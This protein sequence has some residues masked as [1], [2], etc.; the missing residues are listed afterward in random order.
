MPLRVAQHPANTRVLVIDER[1]GIKQIY[2]LLIIEWSPS[3]DVVRVKFRDQNREEWT[4]DRR[5][6]ARLEIL[7]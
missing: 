3:G 7:P 1:T 5:D 6:S 4:D 2:E